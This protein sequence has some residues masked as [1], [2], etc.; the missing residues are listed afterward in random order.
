MARYSR[1]PAQPEPGRLG[2]ASPGQK[3]RAWGSNISARRPEEQLAYGR[4]TVDPLGEEVT[5]LMPDLSHIYFG[6]EAES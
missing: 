4:K 1:A 2:R 5:A 3:N 6:C